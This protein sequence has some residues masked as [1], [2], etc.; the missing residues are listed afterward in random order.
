MVDL[1]LEGATFTS[2][3]RSVW[4]GSY[5]SGGTASSTWGPAKPR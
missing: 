3:E 1:A 2:P 4:S 5:S